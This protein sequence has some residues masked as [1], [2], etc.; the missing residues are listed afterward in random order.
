MRTREV[1]S[2]RRTPELEQVSSAFAALHRDGGSPRGALDL[3]YV[4]VHNESWRRVETQGGGHHD[5]FTEFVE[6]GQPFGLG[7]KTEELRKLVALRHPG[8]DVVEIADR[9]SWLR[10][11]VDSLLDEAIR[12]AAE[13][14]AVGR[15]RV[16]VRGTHSNS[17][18]RERAVRRL[19]RDAPELAAKV[20]EGAV[21]ANAAA[22]EM[23]W[24]RPR[25]VVSTPEKVALSL[26][27]TM[28]PEDIARLVAILGESS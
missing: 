12:P 26:R 11:R 27:R 22:K 2:A 3:L 23:G 13:H 14:G 4:I 6:T 5:T 24:R 9:M 20:A 10:G 15:G 21:T 19:K 17:D 7:V 1:R 18:T 25:I 28:P 16:R 8:E